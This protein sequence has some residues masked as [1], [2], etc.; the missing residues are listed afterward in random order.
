[1]I[2]EDRNK[3]VVASVHNL[4]TGLKSIITFNLCIQK[5]WLKNEAL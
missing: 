5:S 2:C 1:M 4:N 3:R